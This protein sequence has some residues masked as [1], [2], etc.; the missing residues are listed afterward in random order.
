MSW[1]GRGSHSGANNGGGAGVSYSKGGRG[2]GKGRGRGGR[3]GRGGYSKPY[4]SEPDLRQPKPSV[5][6][7]W[8]SKTIL[9][10]SWHG[11]TAIISG[12]QTGADQGGLRA[13]KKLNLITGGW[14]P[15]GFRTEDGVNE[16]L[17]KIY[18]VFE[19]KSN[20]HKER[21]IQNADDADV[22]VAFRYSIPMTG[23]GTE[24]TINHL[25]ECSYHHVQLQKPEDGVL[26]LEGNKPAIV[27]WDLSE[28]N[29]EAYAN[30]LAFFLETQHS[31]K[32]G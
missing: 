16:R 17:H 27:F 1:G 9:S 4:L 12:G 2:G 21:D 10:S 32:G 31:S 8:M 28:T 18:G 6:V 29:I 13:G 3:G 25:R 15:L 23:R 11:I 26:E 19:H 22:M 14:A 20:K 5:D 7:P 24:C 30:R